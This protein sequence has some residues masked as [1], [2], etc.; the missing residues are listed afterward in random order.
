MARRAGFGGGFLS[1]HALTYCGSGSPGGV[2][3]AP[4]WF[5]DAFVLATGSAVAGRFFLLCQ[6]PLTYAT[7]DVIGLF[8]AWNRGSDAEALAAAVAGFTGCGGTL[9]GW[10]TETLY[11][12]TS[13]SYSCD[14]LD[15][16]LSMT[17]S[18]WNYIWDITEP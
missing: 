4:Y 6:V 15:I 10:T 13:T 18:G 7:I 5:T 12:Y 2:V 1:A 14:P 8:Y 17:G 3:A 16:T 11:R 9:S